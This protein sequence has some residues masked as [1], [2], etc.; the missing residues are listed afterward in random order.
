MLSTLLSLHRTAPLGKAVWRTEF[1]L[2]SY[3]SYFCQLVFCPFSTISVSVCTSTDLNL[4]C[5]GFVMI[6]IDRLSRPGL[7]CSLFYP[8]VTP[9]LMLLSTGLDLHSPLTCNQCRS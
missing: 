9:L 8:T 3:V 1:F 2:L 4:S 5:D 7:G 6:G